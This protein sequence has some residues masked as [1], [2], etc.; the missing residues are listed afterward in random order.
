MSDKRDR[1]I[2]EALELH[3][4]LL[5]YVKLVNPELKSGFFHFYSDVEEELYVFCLA[6][7]IGRYSKKAV[8]QFNSLPLEGFSTTFACV[9]PCYIK[10]IHPTRDDYSQ[11]REQFREHA[12]AWKWWQTIL[13]SHYFYRKLPMTD[14]WDVPATAFAR[15]ITSRKNSLS[16]RIGTKCKLPSWSRLEPSDFEDIRNF[17]ENYP[18]TAPNERALIYSQMYT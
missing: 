17:V 15:Y 3:S 12:T 6:E 18:Y 11:L 14:S 7:I 16:F 2:D 4:L 8:K 5:S 10:A 9:T 1:I 13:E